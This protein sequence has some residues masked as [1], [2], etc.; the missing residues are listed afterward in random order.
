MHQIHKESYKFTQ[1]QTFWSI[2]W[3]TRPSGGH[4]HPPA[5]SRSLSCAHIHTWM[6]AHTTQICHITDKTKAFVFFFLQDFGL[7][8]CDF[9]NEQWCWGSL[10]VVREQLQEGLCQIRTALGKAISVLWIIVIQPLYHCW[11]GCSVH[12]RS[13]LV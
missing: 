13:R 7:D 6:V 10:M 11:L 8:P 4:H 12:S 9:Q 5:P 3:I 2:I 1:N